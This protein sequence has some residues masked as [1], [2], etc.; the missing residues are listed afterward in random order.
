[1]EMRSQNPT[2]FY[3]MWVCMTWEKNSLGNVICIIMLYSF[4]NTGSWSSTTGMH[5]PKNTVVYCTADSSCSINSVS[6]PKGA[7]VSR[8]MTVHYG[9]M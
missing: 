6:V 5:Y 3:F 9:R 7:L 2:I 4:K 1:M 8:T